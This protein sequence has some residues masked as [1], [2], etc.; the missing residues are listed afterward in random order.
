M[1]LIANSAPVAY[2]G[3]GNPVR[4]LVAVTGLPEADF[5][6][7]LRPHPAAHDAGRCPSG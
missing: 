1:C 7:M 4:T 3:L 2:G 5:S 6:A